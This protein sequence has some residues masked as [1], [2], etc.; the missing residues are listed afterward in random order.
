M[1]LSFEDK[2]QIIGIFKKFSGDIYSLYL[3]GSRVDDTKSGGDIDLLVVAQSSEEVI[4]F[5]RLDYLVE[6]KKVIG[7]RKIDLTLASIS[8][9]ETDSFLSLAFK[10]AIKLA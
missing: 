7:D 5:K 6:L 4:R 1:R 8:E 3:F 9:L 10:T 2:N